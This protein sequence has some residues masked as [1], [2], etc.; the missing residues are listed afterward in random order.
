MAAR[1]AGKAAKSHFGMS[2]ADLDRTAAPILPERS[3]IEAA[4]AALRVVAGYDPDH[5]A[6]AELVS[7][8]LT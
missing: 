7:R 1:I 2:L 3:V 5:A 8:G 6:E 4:H